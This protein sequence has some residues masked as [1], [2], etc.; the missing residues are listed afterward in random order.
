M[1]DFFDDPLGL[2][3][4]SPLPSSDPRW[5]IPAHGAGSYR[6]ASPSAPIPAPPDVVPMWRQLE[7]DRL[8]G[9]APLRRAS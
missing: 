8:A 5:F 3:P 7:G 9:E 2:D 6:P 1:D 4:L